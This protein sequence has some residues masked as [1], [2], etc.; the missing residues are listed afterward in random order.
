MVLSLAFLVQIGLTTSRNHN[1]QF[2]LWLSTCA[3]EAVRQRGLWMGLLGVLPD[4]PRVCFR[5]CHTQAQHRQMR[6]GVGSRTG[7]VAAPDRCRSDHIVGASVKPLHIALKVGDR[8]TRF[9]RS[10]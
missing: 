1:T 4:V 6:P 8:A 7:Q 2:M 5:T 3:S 9:S 10:T